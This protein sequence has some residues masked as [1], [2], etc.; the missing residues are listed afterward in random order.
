MI[1]GNLIV[2]EMSTGTCN[3]ISYHLRNMEYDWKYVVKIHGHML[4]YV[5]RK[6][7]KGTFQV[8]FC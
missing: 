4:Q 8:P 6:T 7:W 2:E 1:D 5:L 3:E